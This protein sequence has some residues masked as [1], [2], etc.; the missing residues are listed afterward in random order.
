MKASK[1]VYCNS[2][3]VATRLYLYM[4]R[5]G[6]SLSRREPVHPRISFFRLPVPIKCVLIAR[7]AD[8]FQSN[9]SRAVTS[10]IGIT[11]KLVL[12]STAHNLHK[13]RSGVVHPRDNA[14]HGGLALYSCSPKYL[15][16]CSMNFHELETQTS[17]LLSFR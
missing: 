7:G 3:M 1:K 15:P 5:Y 2:W 8:L 17:V 9:R 6:R 11:M 16:E 12:V 13:E 4:C 14:F 10:A